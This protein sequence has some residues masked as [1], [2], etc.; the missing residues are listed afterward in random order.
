M[1]MLAKMSKVKRREYLKNLVGTPDNQ[2]TLTNEQEA[3]VTANLNICAR[4]NKNYFGD[5]NDRT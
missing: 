4:M 3:N 5:H 2:T 1:T